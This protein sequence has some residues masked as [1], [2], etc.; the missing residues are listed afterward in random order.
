M[1]YLKRRRTEKAVRRWKESSTSRADRSRAFLDSKE[2]GRTRQADGGKPKIRSELQIAPKAIAARSCQLLSGHA[3]ATA[4]LKE[5]WGWIDS[6]TCWWC[7]KG[8]RSKEHL[9]K[10]CLT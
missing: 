3:M 8:G 2:G 7:S 10:E 5:K 6:D 9:F 1:A 4:S